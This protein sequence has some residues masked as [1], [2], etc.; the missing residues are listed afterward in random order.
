M[1]GHWTTGVVIELWCGYWTNKKKK[2][3]FVRIVNTNTFFH[4][5][6]KIVSKL[7]SYGFSRCNIWILKMLLQGRV[8]IFWA[9]IFGGGR[10]FELLTWE[11]LKFLGP[12]FSN[13]TGPPPNSQWPLPKPEKKDLNPSERSSSAIKSDDQ[14][15]CSSRICEARAL[16]CVYT[17]DY[18]SCIVGGLSQVGKI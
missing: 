7:R 13:N 18:K 5:N 11:G 8:T 4:S 1:C 6:E 3:G 14:S 12:R 16:A 2:L 17:G 9:H 15:C 10:I